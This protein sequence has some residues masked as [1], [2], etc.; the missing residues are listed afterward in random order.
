MAMSAKHSEVFYYAIAVYTLGAIAVFA[1][2]NGSVPHNAPPQRTAQSPQVIVKLMGHERG[3]AV[4]R[5][6]ANY[7]YSAPSAYATDII[8]DRHAAHF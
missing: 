5:S 2:P 1:V 4:G 6:A 3:V 8:A 7:A